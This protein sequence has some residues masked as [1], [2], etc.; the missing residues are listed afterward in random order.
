M[1]KSKSGTQREVFSTRIN[2][3]ILKQI[4]YLSVDLNKPVNS[5]LEEAM[6]LLLQKYKKAVK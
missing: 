5:L 4:K 3:D 2:P 6:T 1:V